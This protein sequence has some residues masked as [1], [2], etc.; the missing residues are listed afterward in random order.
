MR[1]KVISA[2]VLAILSFSLVACANDVAKDNDGKGDTNNEAVT[3]GRNEENISDQNED[4]V[5][6]PYNPKYE[7]AEGLEYKV[8]EDGTSCTIT[9][10]GTCE[11]N[12]FSIPEEIDGYSVTIIGERGTYAFYNCSGLTS[13][14]I[15]NSVTKI[16]RC[17]FYNCSGLTSIEIPD[18]VT[19][20]DSEA[21][22]GCSGLTSIEIPNSVTSLGSGVFWDCSSLTSIEIPDS[23]TSIGFDLFTGCSE[24]TSIKVSSG[25]I[26]ENFLK[27][28]YGDKIEYID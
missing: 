20:I 21:F 11:L 8:N 27:S 6:E 16:G 28:Q 14:E 26:A 15:P 5:K 23:V 3:D 7:L 2:I 12:E 13:I 24:L 25:S 10:I 9:G 18:S 19:S 1:K 4:V 17:A 22:Y